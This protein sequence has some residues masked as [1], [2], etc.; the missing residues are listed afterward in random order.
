M[1]LAAATRLSAIR[2]ALLLPALAAAL[3]ACAVAATAVLLGKAESARTRQV[4]VVSILSP[5]NDLETLPWGLDAS[6]GG[7]SVFQSLLAADEARVRT[8]LA[9]VDIRGAGPAL[10]RNVASLSAI[11]AF[12]QSRSTDVTQAL[13]LAAREQRTL[14]PVTGAIDAVSAGSGRAASAY[15]HDALLESS[16][17]IGILLIGFG[18]AYVRAVRNARQQRQARE[19]AEAARADLAL[20]L[21]ELERAQKERVRLLART[22]QAAEDE[23]RRIAADL[24]DG[25]IQRLTAAAFSLDLL[26]NRIARGGD[27]SGLLGSI[28]EQL[29]AEMRSLRRL[30]T[31]LRPPVLDER[32][33]APA[34]GEAAAEILP[35]ET[36]SR[37]HDAI[38]TVRLA[39]EIE[40]AAHR[41]AREALVNVAKHAHAAH[42]DVYLRHDG[43]RL[44][45]VV[46]DDGAGFDSGSAT[47]IRDGH[48]GLIAM[49]ERLASL[50]GG[51]RVVSK[52]GEG[53]RLEAS[54][55]WILRLPE[56]QRALT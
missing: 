34:I 11:A 24:H 12:V 50:G 8:S 55:P 56:A 39:P 35:P 22:V 10:D 36:A 52:P 47:S 9:R 32:G 40:T 53:T 37:V 23:R 38:G 2:S 1:G 51:L 5:L 49:R 42:V 21:E 4:R 28:R 3:A 7:A 29:G 43:D 31:E 20:A 17:V 13:R 15:E 54:L 33:V 41:T 48:V 30:M 26:G 6:A 46:S 19:A 16:V 14:L 27:A 18:F 44:S 45:L 25:P